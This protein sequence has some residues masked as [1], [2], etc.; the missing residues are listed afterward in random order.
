MNQKWSSRQF[1][2]L[3]EMANGLNE[4]KSS[5]RMTSDAELFDLGA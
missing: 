4:E 1:R 3:F 5:L 2:G